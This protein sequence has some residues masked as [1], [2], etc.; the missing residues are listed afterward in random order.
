MIHQLGLVC[1]EQLPILIQLGFF[2]LLIDML[3]RPEQA[4]L[5]LLVRSGLQKIIKATQFDALLRIPELCVR[6]QQDSERIRILFLDP[7][8]EFEAVDIRHLDIRQHDIHGDFAE[9]GECLFTARCRA[10][11]VDAE[12]LEVHARQYA[13]DH[14]NLIVNDKDVHD[15]FLLILLSGSGGRS[16]NTHHLQG[17]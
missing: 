3:Q 15:L 12:L 17:H 9:N 5:D 4:L 1:F 14:G 6:G 7:L 13:F 16:V 8:V 11:D 10:D 2:A